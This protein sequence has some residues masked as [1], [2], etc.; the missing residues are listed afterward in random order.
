[1]LKIKMN[2]LYEALQKLSSQSK[3]LANA[4]PV[5]AVITISSSSYLRS[6][7]EASSIISHNK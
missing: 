3:K 1:M 2:L 5:M 4:Q 7:E 6:G